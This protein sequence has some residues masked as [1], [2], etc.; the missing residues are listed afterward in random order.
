VTR[1]PRAPLLLGLAGVL[2]FAWGAL[3]VLIP[4]LGDWSWSTIGARLT[5]RTLLLLYGTV[6]LSFMSGVNWGFATRA[7]G[8]HAA[9]LYALSTLPALWAV[10]L[11]FSTLLLA[12]GFLAL[13]LLDRHVQKAGLAPPWWMRLRLLLTALVVLCLLPGLP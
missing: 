2:P 6:I 7:E 13:L 5:G 1:I 3:T 9:V 11:G 10:F 12:L 8:R 4:A